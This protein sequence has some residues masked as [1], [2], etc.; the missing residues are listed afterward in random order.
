MSSLL[1]Q[2]AAT[3]PVKKNGFLSWHHNPTTPLICVANGATI[4]LPVP[5]NVNNYPHLLMVSKIQNSGK[6][7]PQIVVL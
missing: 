5:T 6:A 3:I 7:V 2:S 1:K 4:L